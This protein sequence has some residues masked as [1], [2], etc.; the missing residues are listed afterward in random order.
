M[1][2]TRALFV[3]LVAI[4]IGTFMVILDNT[5]V[6][7]ALPTLG[8]VFGTDLNVLQWVVTAYLLAQAA[9]IPLS[10]WLSDRFGVKRVYLVSLVLF[11]AGSA[12]CG[13]APNAEVLIVTRTMQ[14]LGGGMLMPIG[15]AVLYRLTPPER[16]GT[17]F[18][19]FGLPL[20][21]APA[22][23]P[24]L[25]GYLLEHADWRLI[26]LVNVPI[27]AMALLIGQRALP[28][29]PPGRA[30]GRL[31]LPGIVLGPLA[32]AALSF[33]I[34][35]S[36]TAGWTAAPT[37]GG[38]AVGVV[39]LLLFIWREL[40]TF[41]PVLELRVFARRE[42]TMAIATQWAGI[43]MLFGVFFMVPLFLQQ[44][45]GYGPLETGLIMLPHA[46]A[47]A[48]F[49]QI[50]GR[51]FDRVGPRVPVLF[52]VSSIG[53]AVWLL[54]RL[55]GATLGPEL[56]LPLALSGAGVGSMM[57]PLSSHLLNS[58]PRELVGRVTSLQGALQNLVGTLTIATFATL[59]QLRT[60][61]HIAEVAAAAAGQ[62]SAAALADAAAWAFGDVFRAAL[63]LAVIGWALAWTLRRPARPA[64]AP[65]AEHEPEPLPEPVLA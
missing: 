5:V 55:N 49:M 44:V 42:F 11:T 17:I 32:F 62:P 50:G 37:L 4:I 60:P 14:G 33:G 36:T 38:I 20:M 35:E 28:A 10:G 12:L 34:S 29:I 57:M 26:F 18:G 64:S 6:N 56:W 65:S 43:G 58:A 23:G 2:S 48:I 59:L 9:V 19:L 25:S 1:T 22:L 39:A 40:A 24:V 15:M 46:I 13:L 16:L 3:P 61:V 8:R 7:V 31:D 53:L 51:V 41:D 21:V 63:V 54:T 45:R 27:G 52:G 30:V 47:S